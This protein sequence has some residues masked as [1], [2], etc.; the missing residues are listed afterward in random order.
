MTAR[1]DVHVDEV[2]QCEVSVSLDRLS[3]RLLDRQEVTL[4]QRR[5]AQT[6]DARH[7][8]LEVHHL[9]LET[10]HDLVVRKP[11]R[12]ESECECNFEGIG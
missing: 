5:V 11:C 9:L 7:D 1:T 3:D 8:R 2:S 6:R 4:A 12:R 10:R